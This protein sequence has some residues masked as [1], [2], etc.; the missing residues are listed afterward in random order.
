[1]RKALTVLALLSAFLVAAPIVAQAQAA[2]VAFDYSVPAPAVTPSPAVVTGYVAQLYV[3]GVA[4]VL[5]DTCVAVA[6]P[7]VITC[8][9]TLPNIS[10]ALAVTGPNQFQVS[11]KDGILEGPKS[12][13]PLVLVTPSAPSTPRIL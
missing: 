6:A 11:L 9:A 12:V 1:M 5:T 3:N 7:A 4:F 2:T 13:V 8:T 10:S